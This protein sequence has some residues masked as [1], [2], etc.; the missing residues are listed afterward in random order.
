MSHTDTTPHSALPFLRNTTYF[1]YPI[2]L[3]LTAYLICL[4]S[5]T[6]VAYGVLEYYFP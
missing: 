4:F 5:A 2:G 3:V 6:D 1:L